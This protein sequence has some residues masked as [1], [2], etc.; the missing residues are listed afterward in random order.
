MRTIAELTKA[1]K[2]DWAQRKEK[3]QAMIAARQ[4]MEKR[5]LELQK[6]MGEAM[7]AGD[8]AT[9]KEARAQLSFVQASLS[10]HQDEK[11]YYWT[12]EETAPLRAEIFEACQMEAVPLYKEAYAHLQKADALYREAAK[13]MLQAYGLETLIGTHLK[14]KNMHSYGYTLTPRTLPEHIMNERA[15]LAGTRYTHEK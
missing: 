4:A 1:V 13:I 7:K 8:G 15:F 5:E 2:E 10:E 9:W 3:T 6:E 12:N 14:D 11:A